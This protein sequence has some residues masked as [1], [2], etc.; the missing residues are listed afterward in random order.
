MHIEFR[1]LV[2]F[3][4][5]VVFLNNLFCTITLLP[6]AKFQ[7]GNARI[8]SLLRAS[9]IILSPVLTLILFQYIDTD[10]TFG[11]FLACGLYVI[12]PIC[13]AI[14]FVSSLLQL[15]KWKQKYPDYACISFQNKESF[16]KG[17]R[18]VVLSVNG[19]SEGKGIVQWVGNNCLV[20]PGDCNI[21]IKVVSV[22]DSRFEGSKDLYADAIMAELQKRGN[23]VI[24]D[25]HQEKKIELIALPPRA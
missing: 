7:E 4:F 23:Y 15:K 12:I 13:V 22:P 9:L 18:I 14:H 8:R 11:K 5:F 20:P 1:T 21:H 3:L 6:K 10:T 24:V 16:F 17:H 19:Y 2:L 25:N